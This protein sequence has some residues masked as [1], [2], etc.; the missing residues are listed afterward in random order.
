MVV[1]VHH[2]PTWA[3][4]EIRS[5]PSWCFELW[6]V[7]PWKKEIIIVC[8]VVIS[9]LYKF[10]SGL[11]D[12]CS[13]LWP[14]FYYNTNPRFRSKLLSK[15]TC[16]CWTVSPFKKALNR[17]K[18]TSCHKW[19]PLFFL[20]ARW[21]NMSECIINTSVAEDHNTTVNCKWRR[22]KVSS[23]IYCSRCGYCLFSAWQEDVSR[24]FRGAFPD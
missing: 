16:A 17:S 6:K 23:S 12:H 15:P 11:L 10:M 13:R 21:L 4:L 14:H 7:C 18:E 5:S 9:V 3:D 20:F 1:L 2:K 24:R 22:L 19:C 8:V